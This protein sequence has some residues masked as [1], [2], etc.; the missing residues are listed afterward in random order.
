MRNVTTEE[1]RDAIRNKFGTGF[2]PLRECSICNETIGYY[3]EVENDRL[4]FDSSCGC[5]SFGVGH[6]ETFDYL[7]QLINMQDNIKGHNYMRKRF[8]L[9]EV[10][11]E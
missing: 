3:Q 2:I 7:A 5:A 1:V 9:P 10:S 8:G 4:W 6:Y 11:D